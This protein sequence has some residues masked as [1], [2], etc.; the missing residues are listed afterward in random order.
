MVHIPEEYAR[1][2]GV[3][4]ELFGDFHSVMQY[5]S[6]N[7]VAQQALIEGEGNEYL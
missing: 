7:G 5:V 1:P 4:E 3:F 6:E 2:W